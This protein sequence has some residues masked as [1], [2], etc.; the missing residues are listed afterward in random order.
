M[1]D[2]KTI[3]SDLI[4]DRQ[5]LEDA[6]NENLALFEIELRRLTRKLKKNLSEHQTNA[7]IKS[8]IKSF[9]SFF[10]KLLNTIQNT[11]T[12]DIVLTDIIGIRIITP[13]LEDRDGVIKLLTNE[14]NVT[15]IEAK[16]EKHSFNEFGY[17]STHL[18]ADLPE[19]Y[20]AI[21]MPYTKP[22]FEI[23]LR[24]IL[25]EAWAEVEHELI[26]K[27]N[28]SL[29]N[30]SI[31]RKLAS[32]N[33]SL[34]LS[35]VIFQEIRDY[36]K[37]IQ[38]LDDKRREMLLN[39]VKEID[40]MPLIDK[41]APKQDLEA[42]LKKD[43]NSIQP[44]KE[45]DKLIFEALDAHSN[46]HYS[47]AIQIYS[48]ILNRE[49]EPKISSIIFNH[50]GMAYFVQSEY[51]RSIDDFTN[52]LYFNPENY[53]ALNNRGLVYKMES[54]HDKALADFEASI[55]IFQNQVDGYYG[56]SLIHYDL[57]NYS[58]AITYCNKALNIKPD[59]SPAKQLK[60][61][62]ASKLFR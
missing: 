37:E 33:A 43:I 54:Q 56:C 44:Q 25:Q 53:R 20:P 17:D 10:D 3:N 7:T 12:N 21:K 4:P 1:N 48:E 30:T 47:Q 57:E 41:I 35:D 6:Y 28:F 52:A 38:N 51:E 60:S 50:R 55:E 23:Q 24:T 31:R 58:S 11:G 59:F 2:K 32:L 18:L 16:G 27:A 9:D 36:Q 61:I 40:K 13:F 8:R 22:V 39:K 46:Q 42:N 45:L 49:L 29:L 15:E 5:K 26:Y 34:A 14:F 19:G 62:I